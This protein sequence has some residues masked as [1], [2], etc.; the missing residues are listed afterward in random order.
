MLA[1]ASCV[2]LRLRGSTVRRVTVAAALAVAI[3]TPPPLR[4]QAPAAEVTPAQLFD[5]AD[6]ARDSGDYALAEKAYRALA[7]NRDIELRTEARYRLAMML[8]DRQKRW[9]EAAVEMRRI[10]DE[11]PSIANVRLELARFQAMM[12][13]VGA[14]AREIR[15]AQAAG[16]PPEVDRLVR[17]FANALDAQKPAGASI[18]V[19]IARDTNVNRATR[20]ETFDTVIGDFVLDQNARARSGIGLALRG[21][22]FARKPLSPSADLLLRASADA[23]LYTRSRFDDIAVN[24]QVGPQIRLGTDRLSLA[25]LIG[26]RWFGLT[27]F[28][29]TWGITANWQHPLGRRAQLRVDGSA[30]RDD[31]RFNSLRDATRMSLA[32]A[33]ERSVSARFGGGVQLSGFREAAGDPSL[34]LTGG[35]IAPYLFREFG[36]TTA[37]LQLSYSHL[38]AD[39]RSFLYLARRRDDRFSASLSATFRALSVGTFAPLVRLRL[40]RNQSTLTIFDFNRTAAEFGIT[41]AF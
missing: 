36:R 1:K 37:L 40:E 17:F 8:A 39:A 35:G 29:F 22:A 2:K 15:A 5:L 4:A 41:A 10:L 33:V 18:E 20:S 16:L 21:Q 31:N 23:D 6:A 38:E 25:G 26:W 24:F 9:R 11:K 34:S 32:A 14:A 30:V 28:S 13:N 7:A 12:G 3:S 19:A 27:P